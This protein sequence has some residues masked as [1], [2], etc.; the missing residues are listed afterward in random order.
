MKSELRPC[1]HGIIDE[2]CQRCEEM[3]P[4]PREAAP[5]AHSL[6]SRMVHD[7]EVLLAEYELHAVERAAKVDPGSVA[8]TA[9]WEMA[10]NM[11]H[12]TLEVY[13]HGQ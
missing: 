3:D 4:R 1:P 7:L 2:P 5:E 10:A 9:T 12:R 6:H 11:L 8:A 13:R